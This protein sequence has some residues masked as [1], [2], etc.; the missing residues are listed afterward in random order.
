MK[1][2]N[3]IHKSLRTLQVDLDR[4]RLVASPFVGHF[5]LMAREGKAQ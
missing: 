4:W 2:R 3:A 5:F 1:I